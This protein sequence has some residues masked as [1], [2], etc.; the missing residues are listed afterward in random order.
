[1]NRVEFIQFFGFNDMDS[2]I[3]LIAS[4]YRYPLNYYRFKRLRKENKELYLHIKKTYKVPKLI[5]EAYN[6][7]RF[8]NRYELTTAQLIK[9][10]D[11]IEDNFNQD[12]FNYIE[13]NYTRKNI[14]YKPSKIK[15]ELIARGF[16]TVEEIGTLDL[17]GHYL[18]HQEFKLILPKD[19]SDA[20]GSTAI[21]LDKPGIYYANSI[22][23]L[24]GT[25]CYFG[26]IPENNSKN[27][28]FKMWG[29]KDIKK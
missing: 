24:L 17:S 25:S 20:K 14:Q 23:G 5:N 16:K 19:F 8:L 21:C 13:E 18:Y 22:W 10:L 27:R 29:L 26:N 4:K 6:V 28:L 12:I 9:S 15:R 11:Y 2:F 3:R 1:M 7:Y